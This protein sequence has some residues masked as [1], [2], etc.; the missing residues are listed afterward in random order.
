MI[1]FRYYLIFLGLIFQ[2]HNL[3]ILLVA[4]LINGVKKQVPQVSYKTTAGDLIPF[5]SF[6]SVLNLFRYDLIS[7][8]ILF[9]S[10][11]KIQKHSVMLVAALTNSGVKNQVPHFLFK[12]ID[13]YLVLVS[14]YEVDDILLCDS[15]TISEA[16]SDYE[17]QSFTLHS[18]RASLP[19]VTCSSPHRTSKEEDILHPLGH[20]LLRFG[21]YFT[22][23]GL[24]FRAAKYQF[25]ECST[26]GLNPQEPLI[27]LQIISV[28]L[29]GSSFHH[30][31]VYISDPV[32]CIV[33]LPKWKIPPD[34]FTKRFS[35]N[36]FTYLRSLLGVS[37]SR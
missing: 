5:H 31:A 3:S 25:I 32:E 30:A 21:A 1:L 24:L 10:Y 8:M 37:S 13:G 15:L 18:P 4:V 14:S 27:S 7:Y 9:G 28:A 11:F 19:L 23:H 16:I 17:A 34:I 20:L 6:G 26:H 36:K 12:T 22:N 33:I 2:I 29:H 35:E